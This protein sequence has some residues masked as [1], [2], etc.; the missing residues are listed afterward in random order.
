M[1]RWED[2]KMGGGKL[3]GSGKLGRWEEV[4]S[5]EA[6]RKWK[7][8]S[9]VTLPGRRVLRSVNCGPWENGKMGKWGNGEMGTGEMGPGDARNG[10]EA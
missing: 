3:G 2:G 10:I 5:W 4:E 6:V 7:R 9:Q 1:G 8:L